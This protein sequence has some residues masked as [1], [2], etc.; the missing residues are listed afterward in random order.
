MSLKK[1]KWQSLAPVVVLVTT[2][3][4]AAA[5]PQTTARAPQHTSQTAAPADGL[6]QQ[7][8]LYQH[9]A[10]L[11]DIIFYISP[12]ACKAVIAKTGS[13]LLAKAPDWKLSYYR[14][15][16]KKIWTGAIDQLEPASLVNPFNRSFKR[17]RAPVVVRKADVPFF[18]SPQQQN[19]E[20]SGS[21]Q[22]KGL[23]YDEYLIT[24]ARQRTVFWLARDIAVDRPC[25]KVMCRFYGVP[26]MGH[27]PIYVRKNT[28]QNQLYAK[29]F[30]RNRALPFFP[31]HADIVKDLRN[32]PQ[33]VMNTTS[34]ERTP[35]DNSL[36]RVPQGYQNTAAI[37]DITYSGKVKDDITSLINDMAFTS[38]KSAQKKSPAAEQA[39]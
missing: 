6:G 3:S 17:R 21:G 19:V 38:N 5:A 35:L 8:V 34:Y 2:I 30:E 22:Y 29:D 11:G 14:P 28:T 36:Y 10:E 20:A 24:T 23:R 7:W 12:H 26:E 37:V 1:N 15:D 13:C 16:E 18:N 9:H 4:T 27:L 39:K 32:G 31:Q 25:A 33:I